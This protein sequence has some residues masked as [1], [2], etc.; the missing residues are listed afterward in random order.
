MPS[1][2]WTKMRWSLPFLAALLP[3]VLLSVYSLRIASQSMRDFVETSNQSATI[4]I[5]QLLTQEFTRTVGLADAIASVPGTIDAVKRRDDI[6]LRARL[7]AVVLAYPEIDRVFITDR[8]GVLWADFPQTPGTF[9]RSHAQ[10]DWYLGLAGRWKPYI[11]GVYLRSHDDSQPVYAVATP[12][13]DEVGSVIGALVFENK[14]DR[15]RRWLENTRLGQTG[16]LFIVDQN[17]AVV[18]HPRLV[19]NGSLRRDYADID[20]LEQAWG[21]GAFLDG[22]FLDP[23]GKNEV[24]AAAQ[25]LSVGR[26][27]W[28]IVA[29]QPTSEAYGP[30]R[31]VTANLGLAGGILTLFT[32][33]MVIALAMS[34]R[35][36]GMLNRALHAKNQTLRDITSFVS[37]QLRAPVTAMR[38]TIETMMDGDYGKLGEELKNALAG[39]RDVAIQNGSL[40]NDI[41]NVSRID[42]GVIE[43]QVAP[44][45]LK[46]IAERALRDYREAIE[47]A[48]LTLA[49]EGFER[50]MTVL[51]DKEKM[52]EAVTNSISNALK[53]T[54]KGGL[55]I[56]LR[57]D[58]IN[59]CI[60]VADTGE[61]MTQDV[62][63]RLFS[64]TGIT[65][66]NTDSASSTGLGLYIA[67]EFMQLQKGDIVV[68]SQ[69]GKGST[70][71]YVIPIVS[72]ANP[73]KSY[74]SVVGSG[75]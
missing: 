33:G 49:L 71:T 19:T 1:V 35:R 7:K 31:R 37:H 9:G 24:V 2:V 28:V 4:N 8:K 52:A 15:I 73:I 36:I 21:S 10:S 72:V 5:S 45:S 75:V 47:R 58:G 53:H 20:L 61:G 6:A 41:L 55:T 67:R 48:G 29:E 50:D 65:G 64:R 11:S 23:V 69:P 26:D 13:F 63:D 32:L 56:R 59:G 74:G 17:G 42:R 60:D 46:E 38:W 25:S 16:Y 14:T 62:M 57:S 68:S 44:V 39:L 27:R 40:I 43:V 3:I 12:I 66:N 18:A 30:L 54:K 34:H 22:E 70:F 51:A